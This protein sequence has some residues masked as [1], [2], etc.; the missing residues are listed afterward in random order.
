MRKKDKREQRNKTF[1]VFVLVIFLVSSL[2]SVVVYYGGNSDT[3]N[4]FTMEFNNKKYT[5]EPKAD[6]TGNL[7]YEVTTE[8]NIVFQSYLQPQAIF[9][10]MDDL[11]KETIR[12]SNY[13]YITFDPEK[14]NLDYIDFIRF[15]VRNNIPDTK[16]FA[17]AITKESSVYN[18]PVITCENATFSTPVI[19]LNVEN[20]TDIKM[21]NNCINI[22]FSQTSVLPVRDMLVYLMQGVDIG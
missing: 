10:E 11:T 22:D 16:F 4:K 3:S 20:T 7:F 17:D 1:L 12:D 13:F 21:N 8:D 18:L 19:V 5:F 9:L 2:G 15:D 14:E 6:S